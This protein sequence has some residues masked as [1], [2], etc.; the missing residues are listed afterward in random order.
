MRVGS[1]VIWQG[2]VWKVEDIQFSMGYARWIELKRDIIH[3]HM[4]V[5]EFERMVSSNEIIVRKEDKDEN[6]RLYYR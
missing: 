6:S 2:E 3:K 5:S 1:T 4:A